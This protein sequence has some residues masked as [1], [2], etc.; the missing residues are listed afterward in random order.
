MTDVLPR[1]ADMGINGTT[2]GFALLVS[3][4]APIIFGLIP[5]LQI[6]RTDL[7]H[8]LVLGGRSGASALGRGTRQSLIVSE[9][10]LAVLLLVGSGLLLRS[11]VRLIGVDPGFQPEQTV[12]AGISLP[13]LR[14]PVPKRAQFFDALARRAAELPGVRAAGLSHTL[15]LVGDHVAGLIT[16]ETDPNN[17]D[18]A[19]TTNFYAATPG[20]FAA[21]GIPLVRGRGIAASDTADSVRVA[22]VSQSVVNR[23]FG[24]RNPIGRRIRVTQ[25]SDEWREIVGVVGD[26]KQYGL[27][28]ETTLQMYEPAAQHPYFSGMSLVIRSAG[29]PALISG[30]VRSLVRQIDPA[31]PVANTTTMASTIAA[32]VGTERLTLRLL[33]AFAV[34][35]MLM[36][37]VGLYGM[38]SYAVGQRTQEIGIRM[39]HGARPRDIFRLILGQGIGLTVAGIILGL[40]GAVWL[41]S[42][43]R[44][45]LFDVGSRDPLALLAAPAILFVVAI[46][47]TAVPASRAMRIDPIAALREE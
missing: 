11:F 1:A 31:L 4:L 8:A 47:A 30:Q 40:L 32:S 20:Y 10:A 43:M 3:L 19:P 6:S 26:V 42:L 21:M 36:A 23:V 24:G 44:S 46:V 29:D 35:A 7:R 17:L 25:G 15:P 41:T 2:L 38:L 5:S 22:V 12:V 13:E 27:N 33:G 45:L 37:A 28:S 14:Y 39:A 9:V 34:V 18:E 16:E